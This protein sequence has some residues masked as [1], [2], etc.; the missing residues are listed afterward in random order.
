MSYLDNHSFLALANHLAIDCAEHQRVHL[1]TVFIGFFVRFGKAL[2]I[3]LTKI[4]SL[5]FQYQRLISRESVFVCEDGTWLQEASFLSCWCRLQSGIIVLMRNVHPRLVF[6]GS[7]GE[8]FQGTQ[9]CPYSRKPNECLLFHETLI[10]QNVS[11]L[12]PRDFRRGC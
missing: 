2:A 6:S 5:S 8:S 3:C 7:N 12:I 9:D 10:V 11:E 1:A 4:S